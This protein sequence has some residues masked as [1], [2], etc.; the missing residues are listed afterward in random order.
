VQN[1]IQHMVNQYHFNKQDLFILFNQVKLRPQVIQHIS[2]PLEKEPWHTYQKLFVNEWR[3]EHGVQFWNKYRNALTKAEQIY[4]V[5]ASII[6][7]TIG[8]E[9]KYGRHTGNYRVIDSLCNLAF[10]H[11]SLRAS[12]FKKE[13]EEFL[14][15]TRE[16]KLNPLTIM[17]SYAGAIGQPQFMP[18]S[19]RNYAVNFS[20]S[21]KT[22]LINNEVDVIGSI[23]NYYKK[24][25][26]SQYKPIA[27]PGIV[28]GNKYD[29]LKHNNKFNS[30]ILITDLSKYGI[31]PKYKI[32]NN[33]LT[34]KI[35]ELENHDNKEYWLGFHNFD[36]IKRYNSSDL[37]AMAVFQLSTYITALK[38]QL[39]HG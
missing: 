14:L 28:I 3:I 33:T 32:T 17:G 15:L 20:N 22:D 4:G 23:A 27:L 37:Y 21:G 5:P 31:A 8:I 1:F 25:G 13:L 9:T 29:Y 10:S 26:W 7:A 11:S 12:F 30:P 35:I 24:H 39:N 36:V 18:S 2:K 16:E 38:E 6:V 19:Y 34:V